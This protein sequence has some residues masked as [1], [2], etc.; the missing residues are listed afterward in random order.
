MPAK[1]ES[2]SCQE[3]GSELDTRGEV[4][5]GWG[6]LAMAVP[7]LPRFYPQAAWSH[8]TALQLPSRPTTV[9]GN[10]SEGVCVYIY[11]YIYI[12]EI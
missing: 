2:T 8:Q 5:A 9:P 7:G 6:S 12:Y 10:L 11:V 4:S 3:H 1:V